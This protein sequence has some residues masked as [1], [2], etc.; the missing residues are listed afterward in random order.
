MI[1]I[2]VG[3]PK[4]LRTVSFE[5]KELGATGDRGNGQTL[6]LLPD[7][8]YLVHECVSDSYGA[9]KDLRLVSREALEYQ[10]GYSE[11]GYTCGIQ[12]TLTLEEAL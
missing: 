10:G 4:E 9:H 8:R 11:L 2:Q 1:T 5:G 7:G 12:Q 6:Y 3:F